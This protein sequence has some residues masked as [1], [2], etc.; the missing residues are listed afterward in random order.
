MIMQFRLKAHRALILSAL[1]VAS[2]AVFAEPLAL[3]NRNGSHVAI[4]VYAPNIAR[5]TLSLEKELA[6]A[7]PGYG[8]SA[9]PDTKGWKHET[10]ATGDRFIS[11]AISIEVPVQPHRG[12]PS[13]MERYFAPSL[14]PV[15]LTVRKPQRRDHLSR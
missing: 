7:P 5:V 2:G 15:A 6:V 1:L 3:L 10:S 14:P 13:Q 11:N 8:F 12:P 9:A 4:E